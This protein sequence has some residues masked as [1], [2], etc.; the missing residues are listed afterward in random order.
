MEASDTLL[1]NPL[2]GTDPSTVFQ[3]VDVNMICSRRAKENHIIQELPSDSEDIL[4]SSMVNMYYPNR[5]YELEQTNLY[6]FTS[7]YDVATKQPS[8]ATTYYTI[9]THYLKKRQR[10]YLLN[11]FKYNPE[12]EP[13]KYFFSMLL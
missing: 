12:Q 5:S 10:L 2:Y 9:L 4:Y 7:W 3:W 1:S 6:T 11:H 13:E 8:E